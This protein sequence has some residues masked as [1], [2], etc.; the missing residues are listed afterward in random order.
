MP[1]VNIVEEIPVA[2]AVAVAMMTPP[3]KP[4]KPP[5]PAPVVA[6]ASHVSS[7]SGGSSS[8]SSS[9]DQ[10]TVV[11]SAKPFQQPTGAGGGRKPMLRLQMNNK[12]QGSNK[13]PNNSVAIELGC[14]PFSDT[15]SD[16]IAFL[17]RFI[18][19]QVRFH[20]SIFFFFFFESIFLLY[21]PYK[22]STYEIMV[23]LFGVC[24]W[25]SRI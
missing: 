10:H 20:H 1:E 3:P 25:S 5:K 13:N 14:R 9:T 15:E 21:V 8:F 6:A 19:T 24:G 16:R 12:G 2:V 17:K 4:P 11:G 22:Y 23:D 7:S 18:D